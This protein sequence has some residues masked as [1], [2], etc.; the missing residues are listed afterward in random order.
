KDNGCGFDMKYVNKIFKPFQR[1]HILSEFPGTGIGLSTVQRI[2]E[3]HKGRLWAESALNEG[4]TF[5][6]TL[7]TER[8]K[9]LLN[10]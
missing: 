10:S 8:K 1:L 3:R 6:F 5:N 4:S 7:W 2:I 9:T